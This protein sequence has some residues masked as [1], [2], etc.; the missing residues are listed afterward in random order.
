MNT[1]IFLITEGQKRTFTAKIIC[2]VWFAFFLTLLIVGFMM[3]YIFTGKRRNQK[4]LHEKLD[5]NARIFTYN[6]ATQT[7]YCF[8]KMNLTNTKTM[9]ASEF[10]AQFSRGDKYLVEDWLRAIA[11]NEK[12]MDFLQA[13]I[14]L[15]STRKIS[16]SMLELTSVN[17]TK[18]TI[19]FVSHM[20]PNLYSINLK[21]VVK[22]NR[23]PPKNLL[24]S[25]EDAQKFIEKS[26]ADALGAVFYFKLFR[27]GEETKGDD[28]ELLELNKNIRTLV[29][30]HFLGK[31][32]KLIFVNPTDE[33]LID[34]E[35]IS[36]IAAM[37]LASTLHTQIQQFLNHSPNGQNFQIAIG[38]T[39]GTYYERNY[40]LAKE[41]ANKMADA[42][43][44]GLTQEKVLFYDEAFFTSYQQSKVQQ[45]EIRMLI[46]N[47]TFREY[48]TPTL[49]IKKGTIPFH[50]MLILPFGTSVKDFFQMIHVAK[51]LGSCNKLFDT[52]IAKC[53]RVVNQRNQKT[54]IAIGIPYSA[55][56]DFTR[57]IERNPHPNISWIL[58]IEETDL[59]TSSDDANTMSRIFHDKTKKGYQF[60]LVIES[61]T[62]A[63]RGRV[64]RT[65]SYFMIPP[66]F[67]S[68]SPDPNRGKTELRNIQSVYGSYKV[69][70]V[71]CGL[72]T[73][74]DIELGV[75]YGGN[76]FQCAEM[77]MPSSRIEDIQ[78]AVIE[79][80]QADTKYLGPKN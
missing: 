36:K 6:Y 17:R 33:I 12:H 35:S 16:S 67:S 32:R 2:I 41:Q 24:T 55:I 40:S 64:L 19:H 70:L 47:S 45:D 27:N 63:L 4:R 46:K 43:R 20:L 3:A 26:S 66:K 61:P 77:A 28:K 71:Y 58:A 57:A 7:F 52:V 65:M 9:N 10:Y 48:F 78:N 73:Y 25:I 56:N 22:Q 15:S 42:V 31:H 37:T 59:L 8:D 69:P 21:N 5:F 79:E 30:S 80:I 75:H 44:Q 14:I 60:A 38:L 50:I 74:D 1:L 76:M 13:D 53:H 34:T 54:T 39:N 72:K 18:T 68:E 62:S 29:L 23:I 11:Q 51:E 49:D